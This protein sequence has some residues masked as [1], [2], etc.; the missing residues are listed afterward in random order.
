MVMAFVGVGV[1]WPGAPVSPRGAC[2]VRASGPIGAA[3]SP[4]R[5]PCAA[6]RGGGAD[7]VVASGGDVCAMRTSWPGSADRFALTAS[8]GPRI[9]PWRRCRRRGC[10]PDNPLSRVSRQTR[11]HA[12]G[13]TAH[14]V[15]SVSY[16]VPDGVHTASYGLCG[17]GRSGR[18]RV[19][20]ETRPHHRPQTAAER[21]R[22]AW[23]FWPASPTPRLGRRGERRW[24]GMA[25]AGH[26]AGFRR[27]VWLS[28]RVPS[29]PR[30]AIGHAGL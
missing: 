19:Y 24:R 27:P 10:T 6:G 12:L 14:S 15:A 2:P 29:P 9:V 22:L 3:H 23:L 1:V 26:R 20:I 17:G 30:G 8:G 4:G 25:Q 7:R 13:H 21:P 5:S 11:P 16:L 28:P 18:R